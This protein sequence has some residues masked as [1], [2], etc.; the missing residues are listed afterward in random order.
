MSKPDEIIK[1]QGKL[2]DHSSNSNLYTSRLYFIG[3]D[4]LFPGI[5]IVKGK[6]ENEKLVDIL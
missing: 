5:W 4:Y 1:T 3:P 6:I 2:L